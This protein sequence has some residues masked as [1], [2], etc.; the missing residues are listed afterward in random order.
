MAHDTP[1]A[2]IDQ[3]T[4]APVHDPGPNQGACDKDGHRDGPRAPPSVEPVGEDDT[5]GTG[6]P[7]TGRPRIDRDL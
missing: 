7:E 3:H 6:S 4:G 2:T 1:R 5:G